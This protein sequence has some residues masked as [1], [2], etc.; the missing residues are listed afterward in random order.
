METF[1]KNVKPDEKANI[2][3]YIY[4]NRFHADQTLYEYLIE[5][6]LVFCGEKNSEKMCFHDPNATDRLEYTI[7][8]RI[9]L[10]RFIFFDRNLS[11]NIAD[12]DV[13]AYHAHFEVLKTKINGVDDAKKVEFLE[14]VQDLFHGYAV[15]L[16]KRTW[17]AQAM[18]P[19]CPELVFCEAMPRKKERVKLK[20]ENRDDCNE[21][22]KIDN[23]FDFDKRNFLARGGE[24]YY[25]H[26]LQGL[27][28]SKELQAQLEKLLQYLLVKRGSKMSKLAVF[29]QKAWEDEMQYESPLTK[30]MYLSYIPENAYID[31]AD[32]AVD[33]LINFLSSEMHQIKTLEILGKGI[34]LQV[35][36]MISEATSKYLDVDRDYWII[37]MKGERGD[38]VKKEAARSLKKQ[39]SSLEEAFGNKASELNKYSDVKER[40]KGL[41]EAK[42]DIWGIFKSK[43]KEMRCIIPARGAW[44]RFSLDED[45]IRFL[46]LAMVKPGDSMPFDK[47]LGKLYSHYNF[48]IGPVEY[49]AMS[50][51]NNKN[52]GNLASYFEDNKCAFQ[53][54]LKATG[55]LRELSDA[56]SL[57]INPYK[58]VELG[59]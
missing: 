13:K 27:R 20:W 44:E 40:I 12:I 53:L 30:K 37:D 39:E 56:T 8:P 52:N 32:R 36:R 57:V 28:R 24:V 4:G 35:M 58:K 26:I 10:K 22:E 17:C 2:A 51:D 1:P 42:K 25:L 47:F 31:I 21:K 19:I 29:I 59:E 38:L 3:A 49:H 6:L 5:F 16:K 41:K 48:V 9:G 46:V 55:F 45:V 43:G 14:A 33:E 50:L 23:C 18:L 15:V 54:Y 7:E 34:M 11:D